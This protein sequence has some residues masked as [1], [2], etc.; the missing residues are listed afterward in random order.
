MSAAKTAGGIGSVSN[1]S[2]TAAAPTNDLRKLLTSLES[3]T[4]SFS[5]AS[6]RLEIFGF[7]SE[8]VGASDGS[9]VDESSVW[10]SS[11]AEASSGVSSTS[12]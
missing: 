5:A 11:S 1:S 9:L 4:A 6:A 3:R 7:G 2:I 10:F 8:V 12:S